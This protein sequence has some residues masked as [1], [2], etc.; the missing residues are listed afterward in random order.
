M[1][2][3]SYEILS[4]KMYT[5]KACHT[6]PR[7]QGWKLH[8]RVHTYIYIY[9]YTKYVTHSLSAKIPIRKLPKEC[10]HTKHVTQPQEF[11]LAP[12][13]KLHARVQLHTLSVLR[14]LSGNYLKYV[15]IHVQSITPECPLAPGWKLHVRMYT[16][17]IHHTK[18]KRALDQPWVG[19]Y[20]YILHLDNPSCSLKVSQSPKALGTVQLLFF[21]ELLLGCLRLAASESLPQIS[22]WKSWRLRSQ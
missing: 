10:T 14:F 11:P 17:K 7:V 12:G 8:T 20:M 16:Y 5:Y 18:P 22:T 9:I 2:S 1:L 4:T 19:S 15:H 6:T 21:R 13:W 3:Q